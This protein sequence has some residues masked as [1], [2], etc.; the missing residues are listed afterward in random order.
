VAAEREVHHVPR[1][2]RQHL[3]QRRRA[4]DHQ[5]HLDT[6]RKDDEGV[7]SPCITSLRLLFAQLLL[8]VMLTLAALYQP[9]WYHAMLTVPKCSKRAQISDAYRP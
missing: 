6:Q 5:Q 3:L 9:A 7:M 8:V 4:S 1:Q 2:V